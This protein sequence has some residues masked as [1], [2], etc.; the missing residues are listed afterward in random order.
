MEYSYEYVEHA[1]AD[2][3]QGEILHLGLSLFFKK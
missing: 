3:Q 1:V 2:S